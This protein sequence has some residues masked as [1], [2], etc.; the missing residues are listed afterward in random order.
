MPRFSRPIGGANPRDYPNLSSFSYISLLVLLY[1]NLIGYFK[2]ACDSP[3]DWNRY[4]G[5]EG[6]T[7]THERLSPPTRFPSGPID[8]YVT[9]P[10]RMVDRQG[11]KPYDSNLA[12]ITR[13]SL[14]SPLKRPSLNSAS[15]CCP[16]CFSDFYHR[17]SSR[18]ARCS[19]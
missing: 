4:N 14:L 6:G 3:G 19:C 10:Y 13:S 8:H 5:G 7:R 9:S 16:L 12:R 15:N 17:S 11:I 1:R 2:I 18:D